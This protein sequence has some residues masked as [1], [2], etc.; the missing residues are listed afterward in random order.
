MLDP[1]CDAFNFLLHFDA[2]HYGTSPICILRWYSFHSGP[3]SSD[4]SEARVS[5]DEGTQLRQGEEIIDS[6]S[7]EDYEDAR[8]ITPNPRDVGVVSAEPVKLRNGISPLADSKVFHRDQV[9]D[10]Q[11][12][13][14]TVMHM[15]N[16][17]SLCSASDDNL[18][19][20]SNET[21]DTDL[22]TPL[23]RPHQQQQQQHWTN[24]KFESDLS[25]APF[26]SETSDMETSGNERV[27]TTDGGSAT[28]LIPLK[29]KLPDSPPIPSSPSPMGTGKVLTQQIPSGSSGDE[30]KKNRTCVKF[31]PIQKPSPPAKKPSSA[32]PSPGGKSSGVPKKPVHAT[33]STP[34]GSSKVSQPLSLRNQQSESS[35]NPTRSKSIKVNIPAKPRPPPVPAK[36]PTKPELKPKPART[37]SVQAPSGIPRASLKEKPRSNSV[38]EPSTSGLRKIQSESNLGVAKGIMQKSTVQGGRKLTD[39]CEEGERRHSTPPRP[40]PPPTPIKPVI[41]AK[42]RRQ[43]SDKNLKPAEQVS[44][45]V[46]GISKPN[47]FQ[48]QSD[49]SKT[50]SS[51]DTTTSGPS[52]SPTA[53]PYTSPSMTKRLSIGPKLVLLPKKPSVK[54]HNRA[55]S[56]SAKM[57]RKVDSTASTGSPLSSVSALA[58]T[59]S[60]TG[61]QAF[62]RLRS[63][64]SRQNVKLKLTPSTSPEVPGQPTDGAT[65]PPPPPIPPR[66]KVARKP[67]HLELVIPIN[68]AS[69]ARSSP[70]PDSTPRKKLSAPRRPPPS[71]PSPRRATEAHPTSNESTESSS[72]ITHSNSRN[73]SDVRQQSASQNESGN[74]DHCAVGAGSPNKEVPAYATVKRP[75]FRI[76]P[77]KPRSRTP[78][79][80][81]RD[82]AALRVAEVDIQKNSDSELETRKTRS[83]VVRRESSRRAPPKPPKYNTPDETTGYVT[84]N[85]ET[86]LNQ[87]GRGSQSPGSRS[88][89]SP[90]R[91]EGT[92]PPLPSQPI[93]KKKISLQKSMSSISVSE[94]PR[95]PDPV[96]D[97]IPDLPK[98]T[99]KRARHR[100]Y[101]EIDLID[102]EPPVE[103]VRTV[104]EALPRKQTQKKQ[105][106]GN[107]AQ[108]PIEDLRENWKTSPKMRRRPAKSFS[109]KKSQSLM[110]RR[111]SSERFSHHKLL[112]LDP[113][114]DRK[115]SQID[116]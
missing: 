3:G 66:S 111:S 39:V 34:L 59:T 91:D 82:Q 15:S 98:R 99:Y 48:P 101:E 58:N 49:S 94:R 2:N 78:D 76:S 14:V 38:E 21:S 12:P 5:L 47:N 37:T 93:P 95:H 1:V 61:E 92:P 102:A 54:S 35:I 104:E 108:L 25:T 44:P 9:S 19:Q 87:Q 40:N 31:K 36:P 63:S 56:D 107:Y 24:K 60:I 27:L 96:Y 13:P 7:D 109:G 86:V 77:E 11:P 84:V 20:D 114:L 26:S 23:P 42:P 73:L 68:D 57:L 90:L 67:S 43:L 18:Q 51:S 105:P 113:L 32:E 22:T 4:T 64:E 8:S 97:V 79:F 62:E 33:K 70:T 41:P 17:D 89:M 46:Q 45:V 52:Q 69:S 75:V 83:K 112:T 116:K 53:S 88:S 6:D 115:V 106:H 65:S 50:P 103:L 100:E 10:I 81:S 28:D 110:Y 16:K 30:V 74:G 80:L 29:T 71:P 55:M 72:Q 85:T